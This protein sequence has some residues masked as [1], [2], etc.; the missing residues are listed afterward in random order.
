[1][2]NGKVHLLRLLE[3]TIQ[4][5]ADMSGLTQNEVFGKQCARKLSLGPHPKGRGYLS[6]EHRYIAFAAGSTGGVML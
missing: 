3:A 5:P 6:P 2:S 1:M 4:I